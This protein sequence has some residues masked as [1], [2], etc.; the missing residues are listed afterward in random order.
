MKLFMKSEEGFEVID[1]QKAAVLEGRVWDWTGGGGR[2]GR[3][4]HCGE[5]DGD[6]LGALAS[7]RV[8]EEDK[9]RVEEEVEAIASTGMKD[10]EDSTE[11][12]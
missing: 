2:V 8:E 1:L 10:S 11:R 9:E 7:T 5:E 3:V 12:I 6:C 4:T